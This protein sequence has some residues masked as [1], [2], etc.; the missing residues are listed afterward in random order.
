M[1]LVL[2]SI[3]ACMNGGRPTTRPICDGL[4]GPIDELNAALLEDGGPRSLVAGDRVI[5][6]FD[7][8]CR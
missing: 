5:A 6:G 4:A 1:L 2:A 7:A 3:S 8:G